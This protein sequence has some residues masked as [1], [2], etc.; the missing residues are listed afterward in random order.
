MDRKE[1]GVPVWVPL[2]VE[3][4]YCIFAG[5]WTQS[6]RCNAKHKRMTYDQK[7]IE[8]AFRILHER[9]ALTDLQVEEWLQVPRNRRLLADLEVVRE[10]R[11]GLENETEQETAQRLLQERE[12]RRKTLRRTWL[13]VLLMLLV[14]L[15]LKYKN[16]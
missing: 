4:N 3:E 12:S 7:E 1:K 10:K 15:L 11:A 13:L 9:E 6:L 8:F 2:S 5:E 16:G 14:V